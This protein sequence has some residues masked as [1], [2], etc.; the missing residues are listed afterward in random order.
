MIAGTYIFKYR[1]YLDRVTCYKRFECNTMEDIEKAIATITRSYGE[2]DYEHERELTNEE[3][4]K[5]K[6]E[7]ENQEA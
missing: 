5:R 7:H 1:A 2:Y 6:E 3:W 4:L